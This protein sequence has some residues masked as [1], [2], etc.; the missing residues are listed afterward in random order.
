MGQ[1]MELF[2]A[3]D[4]DSVLD[5]GANTGQYGK[6]LRRLGYV[7]WLD[8]F[9]P[10]KAAFSA[11]DSAAAKDAQW[12]AHRT[13]LG[14]GTSTASL[15][16]W[17]GSAGESSSIRLPTPALVELLG[18]PTEEVIDVTSLDEWLQQH[19]GRPNAT[20]WLKIDTQGFER[21]VLTGARRTLGEVVGVEIE[22][23]LRHWY[24]GSADLATL[25]SMLNEAGLRPASI[26]TERFRKEWNG[27][28]DVDALFVR[29]DDSE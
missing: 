5:V 13:A 28:V 4:V 10:M 18:A 17:A 2:K 25:M 22:L 29:S 16:A 24:E 27:A 12:R 9:E 15:H 14:I 21:E 8:S 26:M 19:A 1:R 20:R 7:G 23:P 3:F 6:E 11:L